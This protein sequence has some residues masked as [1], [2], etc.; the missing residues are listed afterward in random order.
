MGV[1]YFNHLKFTDNIVLI[2][3]DHAELQ[4]VISVLCG[5]SNEIVLKINLPKIKIVCNKLAECHF[6]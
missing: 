4:K 3:E 5:A 1:K 2:A 6:M